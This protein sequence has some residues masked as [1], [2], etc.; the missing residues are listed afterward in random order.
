MLRLLA[1]ALLVL[2]S[3]IPATA[4]AQDYYDGFGYG[5]YDDQDQANHP[6]FFCP[7]VVARTVPRNF[8]NYAPA[9]VIEYHEH[10]HH[11]HATHYHHETHYHYPAP[12]GPPLPI[13]PPCPRP[14]PVPQFYYHLNP[15]PRW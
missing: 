2:Y 10:H 13:Q 15:C 12:V 3:A 4:I 8:Y 6:G 7:P 14:L 9:P 5:W 11:Y 1:G